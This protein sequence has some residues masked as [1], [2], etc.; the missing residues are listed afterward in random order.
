MGA[1][2]LKPTIVV[3]SDVS[4]CLTSSVRNFLEGV[5]IKEMEF[6]RLLLFCGEF[7]PQS[8]QESFGSELVDGYSSRVVLERFTVDFMRLIVLAR[9]QVPSTVDGTVIGHLDNPRGCG[10]LRNVE[11]A[12]LLKD[13]K[14]KLLHEI[15][16]LGIVS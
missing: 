5:A 8:S 11:S 15:F 7:L 3:V 14:K 13:K 16:C 12:S 2:P 9:A 10:P 6:E 1:E 4:V